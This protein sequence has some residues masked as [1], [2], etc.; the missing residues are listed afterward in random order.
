MGEIYRRRAGEMRT[1]VV[2]ARCALPPCRP[3]VGRRRREDELGPCHRRQGGIG[4]AGGAGKMQ[5]CKPVGD[6]REKDKAWREKKENRRE[7]DKAWRE[8]KENRRERDKTWREKKKNRKERDK[9]W[10]EKKEK[11]T[12]E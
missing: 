5:M 3:D 9:A 4:L 7:R 12:K 2:Q 11:K 1:A 10:R 6:G 8:K